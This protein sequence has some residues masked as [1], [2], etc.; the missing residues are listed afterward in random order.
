MHINRDCLR[1]GIYGSYGGYNLGDEAILQSIIADVRANVRA[2][3][4]VFTRDPEDTLRRHRVE[5]AIPSWQMS[6]EEVRHEVERLDFL[7]LGGGGILYDADARNYLREPTIA[8]EKNIPVMVYAISAG[9][10]NNHAVRREV[11][12]FL[13]RVTAVTVR[14]RT[15]LRLLE[16]LGLQREVVLT[17]DPAFRNHYPITQIENQDS[18]Q[19]QPSRRRIGMSVREPGPAAP[20]INE[21]SYQQ[22]LADSADFIVERFGAEVV[23][24]PMERKMKDLQQSHAVISR[25]LRAEY[26]TVLQDEVTPDQL[27]R[28]ICQLDFC[29]GMRLHF[30]LFSALCGV[31]FVGLPYSPKVLAFLEDIGMTE[32]PIN[33]V[34]AGRLIAHIDYA[35]DNRGQVVRY[36]QQHIPALRERASKN[37][38]IALSVLHDRYGTIPKPQ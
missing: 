12:H 11:L 14:D 13:E 18:G 38:Q 8:L 36:I 4:T 19:R 31:P 27:I 26:A 35:W 17:A 16:E 30:L 32:P 1:I 6:R 33:M 34:N 37:I 20:D 29:I 25:M 10:L 28:I 7:I 9:P 15:A 24:V 21:H 5:H 2:E 22:M 23:F 3:L